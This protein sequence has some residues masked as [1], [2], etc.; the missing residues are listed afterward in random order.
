MLRLQGLP[1]GGARARREHASQHLG[2]SGAELRLGRLHREARP[3]VR[4]L[5]PSAARA[6]R[7]SSTA[8]RQPI[9]ITVPTEQLS[10]AEEHDI[11]FNRGVAS[12]QAY[13]REF[14]NKKP[15][16]QLKPAPSRRAALQWL[17]R[18]LDEAI[19]KFIDRAPKRRHPALLLLRV[20][21]RA[22]AKRSRRRIDRG[23][24]VQ[25][26]IDAKENEHKDKNG[27]LQASFPRDE[28]LARSR[29]PA[30]P[31]IGSSCARPEPA[32]IQHNKFMVLLKGRQRSPPRSGPA[33]PTSPRAA[34]TA[35]PM[36]ATG[37][38]TGGRRA[39]SRPTGRSLAAEPGS[40]KGDDDQA[41]RR[42][43]KNAYRAAGR[44]ILARGPTTWRDHE[45]R[46][47]D[48][49]PAHGPK[50]LDLYVAHRRRGQGGCPASRSRSASTSVQEAAAGQH[51]QEPHRL[52][53]AREGGQAR[54]PRSKKPFVVIN[55]SNN[56]YKAWGAFL[57]GPALSVGAR[58]QRAGSSSS[59]IT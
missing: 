47:D 23:V 56:V 39:R 42:K 55:A 7:T 29:R 8:P 44:S 16:D 24:D 15:S 53:A 11:F 57:D 36:S 31:W 41:R 18:D 12:S 33:R 46:H 43:K 38:A 6:R 28:N 20:P 14:G 50:V 13:A 1:V 19:L 58:D 48:L 45:G 37:C 26:I 54:T 49:Q 17:S 9:R 34:S 35:R 30:S 2:S 27:K 22:V 40:A 51:R 4:V 5:V 3:Q 59:T 10:T 32:S 25:I 21:L 52:P